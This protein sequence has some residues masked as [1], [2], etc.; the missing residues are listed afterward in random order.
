MQPPHYM[1]GGPMGQ[2]GE[3]FQTGTDF[4]SF[5]LLFLV[6]SI[7]YQSLTQFHFGFSSL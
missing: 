4:E 3:Y 2:P 7:T 6:F 5:Q 1:Q